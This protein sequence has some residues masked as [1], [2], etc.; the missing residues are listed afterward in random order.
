MA[1]TPA[2]LTAAILAAGNAVYP[3]SVNLP[4]IATAIGN[5][6]PS[7]LPIPTNV[8]TQG[9]T[10]GTAG[11]GTTQGKMIFVASGQVTAAF[12]AAGLT[13]QAFSGLA[14]AVENGTSS[15][16]NASAQYSGTSAGVGAGTDTTKISLSNAAT[17][18]ALML[19]NL[20]SVGI[21]GP[22]QAQL[23]TAL[24]NGI[25]TLVQTGFGFGGVAGAGSPVPASGTS[26]SV[27]F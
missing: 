26:V 4:K 11:A 18:I 27:V 17:L 1:V 21:T 2:S 5:A 23:G 22:T 3:G 13:G 10:A 20:A 12:S 7:W 25:S 15:T 16:L 8:L 24:G 9:V 19:S 14:T 6:V